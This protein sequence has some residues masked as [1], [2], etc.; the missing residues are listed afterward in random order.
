MNKVIKYIKRNTKGM[1]P[2]QRKMWVDKLADFFRRESID[3]VNGKPIPV[4][5]DIEFVAEAMLNKDDKDDPTGA[6]IE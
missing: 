1:T 6:L 4:S 2:S 5:D 3:Y